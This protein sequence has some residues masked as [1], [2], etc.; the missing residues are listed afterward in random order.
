MVDVEHSDES[1]QVDCQ[2]EDGLY[3]SHTELGPINFEF[4]EDHIPNHKE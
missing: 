4:L 2:G 3:R 1:I